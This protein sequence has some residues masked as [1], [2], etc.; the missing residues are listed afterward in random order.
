MTSY[1][2]KIY[3]LIRLPEEEM[4]HNI[5]LHCLNACM[6]WQMVCA[7]F[8]AQGVMHSSVRGVL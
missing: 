7:L 5:L 2:G 3:L 6:L 1:K 8:N 4:G